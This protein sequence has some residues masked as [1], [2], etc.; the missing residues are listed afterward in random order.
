MP[1]IIQQRRNKYKCCKRSTSK[2]VFVELRQVIMRQHRNSLLSM[3]DNIKRYSLRK[4]GDNNTEE[5]LMLPPS[6]PSTK[7][8]F[9]TQSMS[10]SI[11]MRKS[12]H[13][14][15]NKRCSFC[16][17]LIMLTLPGELALELN[18]KHR[19]HREC[20]RMSL[21]QKSRSLPSCNECGE[22]TRC[23]DNEIH[24]EIIRETLAGKVVDL[25]CSKDTM[26]AAKGENMLSMLPWTSS[27]E[28]LKELVDDLDSEEAAYKEAIRPSAAMQSDK[29]ERIAENEFDVCCSVEIKPPQITVGCKN[30][31][32]DTTW[33]Q[34]IAAEVEEFFLFNVEQYASF[35]EELGR[36][37]IFDYLDVSV[38]GLNWDNMLVSLFEHAVLMVEGTGRFLAG[39]ITLDHD[40]CNM[41][42]DESVLNFNLGNDYLPE[43][44][45]RHSNPLVMIKWENYLN[46]CLS[47]CKIEEIPLLHTT[48]NAWNVLRKCKVPQEGLEFAKKL[49]EGSKIHSSLF[50][51]M[52]P[53]PPAAPLSIAISIC[54]INFTE[55][56][57]ETYRNNI[58]TLLKG[59]RSK[60]R[61][62]D[63]FGL[64]VVGI[65]GEGLP[66]QKAT[67]YGCAGCKWPIWDEI[68]DSICIFRA[69]DGPKELLDNGYSEVVIALE[70]F[71]YLMPS[72]LQTQQENTN[73][74]S[75]FIIVNSRSCDFGELDPA[76][77]ATLSKSMI[78]IHKSNISVELV[79][80]GN[81]FIKEIAKI[82]EMITKPIQDD[83]MLRI[84]HGNRWKFFNSFVDLQ[85]SPLSVF[86]CGTNEVHI[87]AVS[88][89]FLKKAE[90]QSLVSF[91][92]MEVN[93]ES[94]T[95]TQEFDHINICIQHIN[96]KEENYILVK[97]RLHFDD[98]AKI[99]DFD[100]LP[101]LDYRENWLGETGASK[102]LSAKFSDRLIDKS[103][104]EFPGSPTIEGVISEFDKDSYNVSIPL[105]SPL[106]SPQDF[107]FNNKKTELSFTIIENLKKIS[108]DV[109]NQESILQGLVSF[110]SDFLRGLL[111]TDRKGY[112]SALIFE[113]QKISALFK[114]D[115]RIAD[116]ACN[117]FAEWVMN[118]LTINSR[119]YKSKPQDTTF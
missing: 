54:A 64:I 75:K 115:P 104:K 100:D 1:Q 91:S 111:F 2:R 79:K 12:K 16:N 116:L 94:V 15:N 9:F 48:C 78:C 4:P 28:T 62:V 24:E 61:P 50:T 118:P 35:E 72:M 99:G 88:V 33:R 17:E 109:G 101:I 46:G 55:Q 59:I 27:K 83:G 19:C 51:K 10:D 95:P 8:P 41:Y 85:K 36:L 65:D 14:M 25:D 114:S 113:L 37:L 13:N 103:Y 92:H 110:I 58:I 32:D 60:L 68:F 98:S 81:R 7:R 93:R 57:N 67:Y 97:L 45:F 11:A 117:D 74:V 22:K 53:P 80:I 39:K 20:Y 90:S 96:S 47:N 76:I 108:C 73:S 5:V 26:G 30:A 56:D 82:N 86:S 71:K 105:V 52:I 21:D 87:P 34:K 77:E 107:Y 31:S 29:I 6:P 102:C 40:I 63:K 23:L 70:K 84:V 3:W 112:F 69:S 44:Q 119:D 89:L 43:V 18:C 42:R 106:I 66:N 38:N 49:E